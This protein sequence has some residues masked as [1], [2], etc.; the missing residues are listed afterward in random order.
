MV[1]SEKKAAAPCT[2]EPL[3]K[4]QQV[5]TF[6]LPIKV[7]IY[8]KKIE[9]ELVKESCTLSPSSLDVNAGLLIHWCEVFLLDM[10]CMNF[11]LVYLCRA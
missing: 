3:T 8:N 2:K 4:Q 10:F 7:E 9:K 5:D 11:F 6:I 1:I